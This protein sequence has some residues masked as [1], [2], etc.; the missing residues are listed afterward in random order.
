M[1]EKF[2]RE[3]ITQLRIKKNMSEYQLSLDLGKNKGYIQSITSGKA[4]PSMEQFFEICKCL[5][6]SPSKFFEE[7]E[8]SELVNKLC[9]LATELS[10][11]DV[12]ILISLAK[13]L[14][15]GKKN[16]LTPFSWG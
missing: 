5:D 4:L 15:E 9:A 11:E 3:R 6:V 16:K 12:M 10:E 8:T 13:R 2:L 1:D 14:G 7:T